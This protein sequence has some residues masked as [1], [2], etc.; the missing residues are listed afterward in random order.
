ME[1]DV[2]VHG[3][4]DPGRISQFQQLLLCQILGQVEDLLRCLWTIDSKYEQL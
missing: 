1:F 3:A 4:F 2:A